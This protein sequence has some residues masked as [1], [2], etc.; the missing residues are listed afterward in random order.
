MFAGGNDT[1][2]VA[3]GAAIGA[4]AGAGVGRYMDGQEEDMRRKVAASG[5]GL[6]RQ[7]DNIVPVMPSD[8]TFAKGSGLPSN[9]P[10]H[11]HASTWFW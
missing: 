4:L 7:G 2:N 1:R 8:V 5:I 9:G 11:A 10:L 3:V 6:Q